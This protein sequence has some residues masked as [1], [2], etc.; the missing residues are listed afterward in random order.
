MIFLTGRSG[1]S[2]KPRCHQL[3]V[4]NQPKACHYTPRCAAKTYRFQLAAFSGEE[5]EI[6]RLKLA[7]TAVLLLF[8]AGNLLA[9]EVFTNCVTDCALADYAF[10]IKSR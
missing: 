4:K 2:S 1:D 7:T 8:F 9:R 6:K 3:D 10:R 5:F